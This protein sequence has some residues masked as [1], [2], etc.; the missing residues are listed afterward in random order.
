VHKAS[1][2]ILLVDDEADLLLLMADFLRN[3]G[4]GVLTA[5]EAGRA[6]QLLGEHPVDL[7][8][9]DMNLAGE[10]GTKLMPFIQTNYPGMSIV[11]YT[12]LE[13]DDQQIK[14][15]LKQGA[16]CYVNKAQSPKALLYAI[17]E[18][19]GLEQSPS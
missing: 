7:I 3:H 1:R 4:L 8:V 18:I 5:L 2:N 12:G 10:D 15:L 13:H 9:L 6:M 11:L 19:L 14:T 17:R 16:I